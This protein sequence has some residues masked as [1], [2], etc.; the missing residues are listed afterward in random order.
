MPAVPR[1]SSKPI[2]E[3]LVPRV[4]QETRKDVASIAEQVEVEYGKKVEEFA[5]KIAEAKAWGLDDWVEL[6]ELVKCGRLFS[7]IRVMFRE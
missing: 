3:E 7:E 6:D 2:G 1:K 4:K 5:K